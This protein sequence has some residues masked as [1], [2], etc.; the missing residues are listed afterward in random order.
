MKPSTRRKN[1]KM[2]RQLQA[3]D[4]CITASQIPIAFNHAPLLVEAANMI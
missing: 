1:K 4:K 3:L 2:E